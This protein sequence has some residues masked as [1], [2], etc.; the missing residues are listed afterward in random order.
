MSSRSI[1]ESTAASSLRRWAA[2]RLAAKASIPAWRTT[3]QGVDQLLALGGDRDAAHAPVVGVLDPGGEPLL[4]QGVDRP[5]HRGHGDAEAP[6]PG[7]STCRGSAA[8]PSPPSSSS[9]LHWVIERPRLLDHP[10]LVA[11]VVEEEVAQQRAEPRRR[12][13]RLGADLGSRPRSTIAAMSLACMRIIVAHAQLFLKGN[14]C[15]CDAHHAAATCMPRFPAGAGASVGPVM[16]VDHAQ[17]DRD[18][19]W[20][21]FTQQQGW[22]EEEPLM[23]ER[24][25]GLAPDRRRRAPLP[26]RRLLALVQRPRPSPPGDRRRGRATSSSRVAH[27]TMLGLSHPGAA[28]LAGRLVEIAP[29][30]LSPRLLLGLRLD[31]DRDRAEDGL[32]V[33]AAARRPARAA[34][35]PS[36]TCAT[37]TT[38][39]RSARSRSAASTS[40]TPT[41]RPLLFDDPRRRAR[42]RRRPGAD[43]RLRTRRRSPR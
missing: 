20:H 32:P 6:R 26:R 30:G 31:R 8:S 7:R 41:Y 14:S 43:P 2:V 35:P 9:A 39:T 13:L 40:S 25:R 15:S 18:H 34:A 10:Q 42:R 11:A 4:D 29:P 24:G 19:L 22:V 38:A 36:S 27:S 21:P 3:T 23:I 12:V 33:P 5:A 37:P 16:S 17:L 1:S 28:E